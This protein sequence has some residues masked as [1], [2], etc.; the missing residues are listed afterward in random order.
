MNLDQVNGAAKVAA[1]RVQQRVGELI[2]NKT[3]QAKGI[4]NQV[5]GELQKDAGDV[6]AALHRIARETS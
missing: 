3:L 4:A 1:G 2:G 5:E 6:E